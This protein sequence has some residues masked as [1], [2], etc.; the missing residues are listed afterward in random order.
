MVLMVRADAIVNRS[1]ERT[2]NGLSGARGS[3]RGKR[4]TVGKAEYDLVVRRWH[5]AQLLQ[6]V[7]FGDSIVDVNRRCAEGGRLRCRNDAGAPHGR[8]RR[9]LAHEQHRQRDGW[10]RDRR[11][12]PHGLL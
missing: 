5:R 9:R 11:R 12:E 8:Q 1:I 3:P 4:V 7:K 10:P 6:R 2:R